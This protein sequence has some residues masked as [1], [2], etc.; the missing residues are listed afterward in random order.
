MTVYERAR[1][2]PTAAFALASI[3]N[4][5]QNDLVEY[6]NRKTGERTART[7]D[8]AVVVAQNKVIVQVPPSTTVDPNLLNGGLIEFRLEKG[9]IDTLDHIHVLITINN[10]TGAAVVLQPSMLLLDHWELFAQNG[11]RLLFQKYAHEMWSDLIY[12]PTS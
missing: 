3:P 10:A 6:T 2:N 5:I 4:S 8:S 9:Y 11:N 7:V 1:F 12:L